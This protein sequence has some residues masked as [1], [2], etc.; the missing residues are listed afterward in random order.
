LNDPFNRSVRRRVTGEAAQVRFLLAPSGTPRATT[1]A[2]EVDDE[3]KESPMVRLVSVVVVAVA[4]SLSTV[5]SASDDPFAGGSSEAVPAPV[6]A[7]PPAVAAPSAPAPA[8]P[9][10]TRPAPAFQIADSERGARP[11]RGRH[12]VGL[13]I[14]GLAVFGAGYVGSAL[15]FM[16]SSAIYGD[17]TAI[18][19]E[20][21]VPIAGPWLALASANWSAVADDQR[22]QAQ[23][24]LILQGGLQ[25][26]GAVLSIV[27]IS[28]YVASKT[29]ESARRLSFQFAP[30]SGGGLG[31]VRGA[32]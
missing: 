26:V 6:S 16:A 22:A 11:Q 8:A 9:A 3:T 2:I 18:G 17:S 25:A 7:P 23:A 28:R 30:M 24:T 12:K 21:L 10:A 13:M 15:S 14:A 1:R 29:P 5:A 32:F 4:C 27:G 19:P 31:I 20:I